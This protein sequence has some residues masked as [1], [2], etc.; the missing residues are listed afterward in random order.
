MKLIAHHFRSNQFHFSTYPRDTRFTKEAC[1]LFIRNCKS[2]EELKQIQSQIFRNGFHQNENTLSNLMVFCT[3]PFLGNLEYAERIF[4]YIENRCLFIY[5]LMIKGYA[6]SGFFRKAHLLLN[7][8]RLEGLCPDNFTYPF[9]LK[10]IGCLGDVKESLKI[11]GS[12]VKN[13]MEFDLYVCNSLVS[14]YAEMG[15]IRNALQVF[16]EMPERNVVSWS[17]MIS[18]FV[19]CKM[20]ADAVGTFQRMRRE[21]DLKP[22]EATLVSTL[23][24]CTAMKNLELGNEIHN[25]IDQERLHFNPVIGNALL[26]MYAK[27]GSLSIA[28][29]IFDQMPTKNVIC[30]TNMISGCINC[31][32][33]D[34]ARFLFDRSPVKDLVLWTAMI[35]GYV[36]FNRFDEAM[37]LF[38]EIQIMNINPDKFTLVTLLT[39][40]AQMGALE[41]GKWIHRYIDENQIPVTAVVA[42]ALIEMYSKC[43]F[44]D[45]SLEIFDR[46]EGKDTALWTSLICGLAMNGNTSKA[47]ELFSAMKQARCKPD[48][49]TFIGVLSACSHGGLIQEGWEHFNSMAEIY[50]IEPK[51]EHYGCL[52]DLLG[53]SGQLDEAGKL[54]RKIL[55][56]KIDKND[57]IVP[58]YGALLSSC[59]IHGNVDMGE[60]IAKQI[61][62]IQ[63]SDSSIE[64]LIANIYASADRWDDV[65][66][67]RTKMK[68]L[69][70][71]KLPGCSSIEIDGFVHEFL[72]GDPSHPL[73]LEICCVLEAVAKSSSGLLKENE[74]G[75]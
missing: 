50:H 31:G 40:C 43:G 51:L 35:N 72:A 7:Q 34:E 61:V 64:T 54:I 9:V 10:A 62:K 45:K 12:L 14:M 68:L 29:Q 60:Q 53:R 58:L 39:A 37:D 24:A 5:N 71:K 41:Q 1:L 22:A 19:K 59:R 38:Q 13:G 3:D 23:S 52:I 27:C 44:I 26:D 47:L 63:S 48:D 6:K 70:M 15:C 16:D 25:Y 32:K 2:M 67:V 65:K 20:F 66:K 49:I 28:R 17:V 56:G 21:T 55:D 11:H 36:Q 46:V 74:I 8:L 69:G 30:W 42:T 73:M 4:D 75:V 33:V 18:G 57:L